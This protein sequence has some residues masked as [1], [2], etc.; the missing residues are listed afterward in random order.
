M[1]NKIG[2]ETNREKNPEFST[3]YMYNPELIDFANYYFFG[4]G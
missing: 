2:K 4:H 3:M 1:S